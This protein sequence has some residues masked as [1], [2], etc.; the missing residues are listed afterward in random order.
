MSELTP[1]Q[2]ETLALLI[3]GAEKLKMAVAGLSETDL[4]HSVGPG[5]WTIRQLV[6]H[7]ADDGDAWCMHFKKALATPGVPIRFEG[8]PGNESWAKVLAFDKRPIQPALAL[9]MAHRQLIKEL[10][11]YFPGAW[12]Q[13]VTI[14][15][16]QGQALQDVSAQQMLQMLNEHLVEHLATIH[17]IRRQ[18]GKLSAY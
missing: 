1:F 17:V 5:E 3:S 6:H 10:A 12:E 14:V 9:V 11:E 7:V 2:K 4:D 16:S 15:D 18:I 8:F 13:H